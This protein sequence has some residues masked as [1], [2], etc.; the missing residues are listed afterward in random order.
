MSIPV[1]IL[2]VYPLTSGVV[3]CIVLLYSV[4]G[5]E[6]MAYRGE[7]DT[8]KGKAKATFCH[9]MRLT[10]EGT[11]QAAISDNEAEWCQIIDNIVEAAAERALIVL[12][13]D[14]TRQA[15]ID[16]SP[17]LTPFDQADADNVYSFALAAREAANRLY[18]GAALLSRLPGHSDV[19]LKVVEAMADLN[20][21]I[22]RYNTGQPQ[23]HN[24][25]AT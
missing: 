8:A 1:A 25:P 15:G 19:S 22:T 21:S 11:H 24:E 13:A 4:V 12:K 17:P 20:G 5:V 14:T 23:R 10:L 3:S 7:T 9:Y 16:A 18:D 6:S 2:R